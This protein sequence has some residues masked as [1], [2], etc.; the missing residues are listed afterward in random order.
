MKINRKTIG[1]LIPLIL[2]SA[3]LIMFLFTN[4]LEG[5]V[6]LLIP[7]FAFLD[8]TFGLTISV[9]GNEQ[10]IFGFSIIN[11]IPLLII[12]LGIIA[13]LFK[14]VTNGKFLQRKSE[15]L[16]LTLLI[17]VGGILIFFMREFVSY[18]NIYEADSFVNSPMLYITG[19]L[20]IIS[21]VSLLINDLMN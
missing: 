8:I 6:P 20:V 1:L 17:I 19:A 7:D 5:T 14:L 15:S 13:L 9:L 2:L 3:S 21:G 10:Q 16:F 4:A 12:V 11:F 18:T